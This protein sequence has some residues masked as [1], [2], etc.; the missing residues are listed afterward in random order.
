MDNTT[1]DRAETIT[2]LQRLWQNNPASYW[3]ALRESGLSA[4][5]VWPNEAVNSSGKE[6]ARPES[7]K[8]RKGA[9]KDD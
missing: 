8:G 3:P 9:K 6:M 5:D 2:R 7:T 4:Q 1:P